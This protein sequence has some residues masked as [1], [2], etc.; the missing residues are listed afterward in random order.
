MTNPTAQCWRSLMAASAR[1]SS[2]ADGAR[3]RWSVHWTRTRGRSPQQG[4]AARGW[5]LCD[6]PAVRSTDGAAS[7]R[8]HAVVADHR[9]DPASAAVSMCAYI[10]VIDPRRPASPPP[11]CRCRHATSYI[12]APETGQEQRGR[13]PARDRMGLTPRQPDPSRSAATGL[14]SHAAEHVMATSVDSTA[15]PSVRAFLI[16]GRRHST[17]HR[18]A[19]SIIRRGPRG[20]SHPSVELLAAARVS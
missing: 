2:C 19:R 1:R 13:W 18:S 6:L 9:P 20:A 8:T 7:V 12:R 14:R 5:S 16:P 15:E 10:R 17:P 11:C 4:R 3:T